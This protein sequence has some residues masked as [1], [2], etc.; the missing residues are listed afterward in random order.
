MCVCVWGGGG[1]GVLAFSKVSVTSRANFMPFLLDRLLFFLPIL[2][3][4][5][6][7]QSA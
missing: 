5:L 4:L 2:P 3:S 1:G 6:Y 7:L